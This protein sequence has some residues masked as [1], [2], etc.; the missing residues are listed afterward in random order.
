MVS[1]GELGVVEVIFPINLAARGKKSSKLVRVLK[2]WLFFI[3][4]IAVCTFVF[5]K[6]AP[7]RTSRLQQVIAGNKAVVTGIMYDS[8]KPLAIVRGRIV[9]E[10]DIVNG[11]EVRKIY[12]DKVEFSRDGM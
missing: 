4:V 3:G 7:Q 1:D 8:E 11:C 2:G 5:T 12:P 10:G 9:H 6:Y